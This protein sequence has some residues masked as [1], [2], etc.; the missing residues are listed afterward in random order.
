MDFILTTNNMQTELFTTEQLA[1]IFKKPT[2]T[3]YSQIA[4]I[5]LKP[6]K[7][8]GK[9]NY[10]AKSQF[11]KKVETVVVYYPIKTIET[12][13]IYESKMNVE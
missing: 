5:K 4:R 7:V 1:V 10:F 13:Y 12:F 9:L 6:V 11:D 8:V 3:I 2:S